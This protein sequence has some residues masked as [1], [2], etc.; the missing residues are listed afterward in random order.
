RRR[1]ART[2]LGIV[3]IEAVQ[4]GDTQVFAAREDRKYNSAADKPQDALAAFPSVR[5]VV[6]STCVKARSP[7]RNLAELLFVGSGLMPDTLRIEN[8]IGLESLYA[9]G[10]YSNVRMAVD[11]LPRDLM[12][13]LS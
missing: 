8:L 10:A 2:Q 12:R 11:H 9:A 7:L 13:Q 1:S 5:S 6:T 3:P 4:A